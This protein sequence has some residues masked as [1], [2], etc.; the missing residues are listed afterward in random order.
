MHNRVYKLVSQLTKTKST[1]S[2]FFGCISFEM[3]VQYLRF[4]YNITQYVVLQLHSVIIWCIQQIHWLFMLYDY[5]S[6][7]LSIF[8]SFSS[9]P[10]LF[11][12]QSF[13]AYLSTTT[14]SYNLSQISLMFLINPQPKKLHILLSS[15]GLK[16]NENLR[17]ERNI[18]MRE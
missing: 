11:P 18:I 1:Y 8:P 6:F 5:F 14:S 10:S 16:L 2:N 17:T 12:Q 3:T 13:A 4:D 9:C 15:F 7:I